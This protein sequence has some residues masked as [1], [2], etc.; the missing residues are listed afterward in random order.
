MC[1]LLEVLAV[2]LVD[3]LDQFLKHVVEELIKV[4]LVRGREGV[5]R[6]WEAAHILDLDFF[7]AFFEFFLNVL[8]HV[9]DFLFH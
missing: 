4:V 3:S 6:L 7:T 2:L 8:F 5:A 9:E 1:L